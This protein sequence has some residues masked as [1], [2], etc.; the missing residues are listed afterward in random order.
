MDFKQRAKELVAKMTL[1]EKMAQMQY[2]SPAIPRLGIPA[3]NWWNEAL[4]GAAR[5]GT[6]T[7]FPQSIAMAAS[8]DDELMETVGGVISDEVR[9]KYNEYRKFGDTGVYQGLTC[10]S[11]NI[12]IFRDPR[13]GRGHET[14][15][16][17]PMLTA[18]M[19][20]AF[21]RGMQGYDPVYRKVDATLKHYA[22]HSGPE[23]ERHHFNAVVSEKDLYETYLF[24]FKY[25][26]EHA[27]PSAV[28]G[29]YNRVLGEPCCASKRLLGD[30]LRGE[31]GFDG[32]VV[33]DCGA[34]CD[35]NKTHK[36]TANEA[37]SAALAV[38]NGCDLN[39][40]DA[41]KW[42]KT[43]AA[44][45]LLDEE[46][47][48]VSVERLFEA[49]LRLGMFDKCVYDDI[50][51]SIVACKEHKALARQMSRESIVLCKN[52]GILPLSTDKTYAVIGPNADDLSVLLGNYNGTP[53]HYT[54]PL[55]G[56]QNIAEHVIYARGTHIYQDEEH[57]RYF[58][59][60]L[61]EAIIAAKH[62]DV[63]ILCMGINPLLEGE[64]TPEN[65]SHGDKPDLELPA[66]QKRLFEEIIKL[67]K[68]MVFVNVSGSCLN[69]CR[70]DETCNAV[71]QCFY[72]GAEG[73]DALAELLFGKYSPCGR[74]PVT[75]YRSADDLPPFTEYSMENRTYRFFKGSPLYPF[76]HGLTYSEIKENWKDENTVVLTNNGK[77]DTKYSVLKYADATKRKLVDFKKV[78]VPAGGSVTVKF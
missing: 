73:G 27:H 52:D 47:I 18:K 63:V 14:Y 68:P 49:R 26:I 56:I 10:W 45:G 65:E 20:A 12:N 25:C 77:F 13:W 31:F 7:V 33:S 30:I 46:T 36:V 32:Y 59:H 58:E 34:I 11:P 19:G 74:L 23:S 44:M 38:K 5:T 55:E 69:L 72:P 62:S 16:E 71:I 35:I 67:G 42:L 4:H 21:V 54:T 28:M 40:G 78:L 17:D 6:A 9:A 48:T 8:F 50:P 61:R 1:P 37:E 43:S 29:A 70:A 53:D 41:Y 24:A 39:C 75:F 3:Y 76:G 60:P 22:V 51:Y 64:E 15:G 2:E 57:S 66:V